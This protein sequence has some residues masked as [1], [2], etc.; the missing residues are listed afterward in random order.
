MHC[1]YNTDTQQKTMTNDQFDCIVEAITTGQYSWA[2]L[3][4][5]RFA[6][7]NPLHYI[8]YRT[9]NRLMKT[10]QQDKKSQDIPKIPRFASQPSKRFRDLPCL[11]EIDLQ[12]QQIV[13]GTK[14]ASIDSAQELIFLKIDNL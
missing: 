5:L 1:N 13:G 6:G 3:L 2:C 11:E 14:F 9:Y 8:P 4:I 10:H 12:S 7:Y